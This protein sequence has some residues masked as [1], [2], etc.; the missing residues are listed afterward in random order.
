M[1]PILFCRNGGPN[2]PELDKICGNI[3]PQKIVSSSHRLW[4]EFYSETTP[5]DFEFTLD[6]IGNECGSVYRGNRKEISSPK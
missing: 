1:R 5:N 6:Q 3:V 4:I 2:S